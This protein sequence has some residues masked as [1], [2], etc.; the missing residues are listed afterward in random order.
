[1]VIQYHRRSRQM[2][3]L[4]PPKSNVLLSARHQFVCLNRTK[5]YSQNVEI[6]DL[7]CQQL[8]LSCSLNI[9]YIKNKHCLTFVRIQP[10]H[11]Q[12]LLV[13]QPYLLHFLVRTLETANTFMIDPDPNRWLRSLL[14]SHHP[15]LIRIHRHDVV[16]MSLHEK[17]LSSVYIPPHQKTTCRVVNLIFF[18]Q[19]IRIVK[20][21][22][23]K[24]T[25]QLKE[26]LWSQCAH[27]WLTGLVER[28]NY[29][30]PL[31]FKWAGLLTLND[32][33]GKLFG[34]LYFLLLELFPHFRWVDRCR[35]IHKIIVILPPTSL[36]QLESHLLGQ[37]SPIINVITCINSPHQQV[38][39]YLNPLQCMNSAKVFNGSFRKQPK[40][41]QMMF[42]IN[43]SN[44]PKISFLHLKRNF[45]SLNSTQSYIAPTNWILLLHISESK[46]HTRLSVLDR[47]F[48]MNAEVW[49][50]SREKFNVELSKKCNTNRP[51]R[52]QDL[53]SPVGSGIVTVL[54]ER[55]EPVSLNAFLAIAGSYIF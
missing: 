18:E 24:R 33:V 34:R 2:L 21:S 32:T 5:L 36:D 10:N 49:F 45:Q 55:I 1:M 25:R 26:Q 11:R 42:N 37:A 6:T 47:N 8:R 29:F 23:R 16:C 27:N 46:S 48:E 54:L 31:L 22:K 52:L 19:K 7:L 17:L 30:R 3:V 40:T 28:G 50:R 41:L 13:A 53:T 12:L 51:I 15:I 44:S 39:T 4:H 38:R 43:T 9:T 35:I 14:D 20:R